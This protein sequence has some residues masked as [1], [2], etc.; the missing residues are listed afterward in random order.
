MPETAWQSRGAGSESYF[1]VGGYTTAIIGNAG[2]QHFT[3][4][5][6]VV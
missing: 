1:R 2:F 4:N 5:T 3:A 6:H